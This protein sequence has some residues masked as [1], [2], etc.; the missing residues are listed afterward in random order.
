[1]TLGTG[2]GRRND[3]RYRRPHPAI[4]TMMKSYFIPGGIA[5]W[6]FLLICAHALVPARSGSQPECYRWIARDRIRAGYMSQADLGAGIARM[7]SAGMN[8][9]MPKFGSM[10][11][12]PMVEDVRSLAGWGMA[13]RRN[14]LHLLYRW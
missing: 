10:Q 14:G 1:M 12:P 5:A 8:A 2:T 11:S 7:K 6:T 4:L 13:A 9:L 3:P